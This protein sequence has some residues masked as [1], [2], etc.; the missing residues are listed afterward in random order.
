MYNTTLR[1]VGGSIM[2]AV[3]PALLDILE[4]GSGTQVGLSIKNGAILVK[5]HKKPHYTLSELIAMCDMTAKPEPRD[6]EWLDSSPVGK[7]VL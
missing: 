1:K 2:L 3:P 7:E 5:P 4:I 6:D